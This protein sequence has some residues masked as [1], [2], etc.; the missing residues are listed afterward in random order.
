MIRKIK[1]II[2]YYY[3]KVIQQLKHEN[4]VGVLIFKERFI[5]DKELC[6]V[7]KK[8]IFVIAMSNKHKDIEYDIYF[9]VQRYKYDLLNLIDSL[10]NNNLIE[11]TY[12]SY[13]TPLRSRDKNKK[14]N[15]ILEDNK[16]I[17]YFKRSK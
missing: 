3:N 15:L 5:F 13:T 9:K 4:L 2:I 1:R 17:S 8:G 10:F 6:F 14:F 16:L 11:L 12:V 7:L